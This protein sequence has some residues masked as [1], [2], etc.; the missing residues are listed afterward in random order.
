[1]IMKARPVTSAFILLL[2]TLFAAPYTCAAST[3]IVNKTEDTADGVCDADCSLREAVVAAMPGDTIVFSSLFLSSQTITLTMGQIAI[4]KDLAITGPGINYLSISGNNAGRIFDISGGV[5]VSMSLMRLRDGRVTDFVYAYGGAIRA[6]ASVLTLSDMEFNNNAAIGTKINFGYGG[7]VYAG[8]GSTLNLDNVYLHHNTSSGGAAAADD[9][10]GSTISII[11]S[12]VSGNTGN[13]IIGTTVNVENTLLTGNTGTGVVAQFLTMINSKSVGNS[14]GVWGGD[15]LSRMTIQH[16]VI[17]DNGN[18]GGLVNS[19]LATIMDTLIIN[20]RKVGWGGGI[21]NTGTLYITNSS[22]IGNRATENGG[23]IESATDHLYLTNSTVSGNVAGS[24]GL[25]G[26]RGGGIHIDD[27]GAGSIMITNSTISNNRTTGLGGGISHQS[28]NSAIIRNTIIAGN[29][30]TSTEHWDVSGV[31]LS[32]GINLIGNSNGGSGWIG[33]DLLNQDPL[34]APLGINGGNTLTHALLPDSPA[35]NAGNNVLAVNPQTTLVLTTDQRGF[36]RFTG[37][38]KNGLVDI[39]SYEASYSLSPVTVSG[40][41]TSSTGR[42]VDRA[43]IKLTDIESGT[44]TYTIS[45]PFGYY[46]F[47]SLMPGR[48]YSISIIHKSYTFDSPQNFT[49]DQNRD[50]LNFIARL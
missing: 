16:C 9:F 19:G 8:Q 42:G 13:G 35:I 7:G 6:L 39:G 24:A 37:G 47:F 29:I 4:T 49:V 32:K 45:N 12:T 50:D 11:N 40:R 28:T 46:R 25:S 36:D 17:A 33:A 20:N 41:I 10:D 30:S 21:S 38:G 22:I 3:L 44:V 34:L 15:S 26:A 18:D 27:F 43:R 14:R 23:G 2:A 1:L 31:F 5:V 48:T